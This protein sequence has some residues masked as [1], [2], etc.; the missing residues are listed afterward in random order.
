MGE[1]VTTIEAQ[2][3]S[4]GIRKESVKWPLI[5]NIG[6]IAVALNIF[7][8]YPDFFPEWLQI[9]WFDAGLIVISAFVLFAF[10]RS[11]TFMFSFSTFIVAL[12]A[13]VFLAIPVALQFPHEKLSYF[14]RLLF[15]LVVTFVLIKP[16][17]RFGYN[18]TLTYAFLIAYSALPMA[19]IVL[20]Q[21]ISIPLFTDMIHFLYGTE[22]LRDI[23][24]V[25]P[26]VYGSFYN[27]NWF[28]VY[29][30]VLFASIVFLYK[31]K[32]IGRFISIILVVFGV[33]FIV[34]SGSRTALLGLGIAMLLQTVWIIFNSK[35]SIHRF[36][37]V[38]F[39]I[40][41]GFSGIFVFF[42][43]Y[44]EHRLF[45]RWKDVLGLL[46]IFKVDSVAGRLASWKVAFEK[47]SEEPVFGPGV[48]IQAH[49]SYLTTV[50][51]FGVLGILVM[52]FFG[53]ALTV[54]LIKN[55]QKSTSLLAIPVVIAFLIMAITAE[56]FYTTQA[57]LL[58]LPML[59]WVFH[60]S[61]QKFGVNQR[62]SG[63]NGF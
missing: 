3:T 57:V 47:F 20:F 5:A 24:S 44:G 25:S 50:N 26:R 1:T 11:P 55:W 52:A 19:L 45:R 17:A 4:V 14:I 58:I 16:W 36:L 61:T 48:G 51:V 34:L 10:S 63:G 60:P 6:L 54:S 56:F 30:V 32:K 46:D 2:S 39:W 42:N 31:F 41:F 62:K 37:S 49:N 22:K 53:L 43:L 15:F 33:I 28:G 18:A 9:F 8:P 13:I 38:G 21:I 7:R 23:S 35:T 12:S 29:I 59:F 27:A 40:I